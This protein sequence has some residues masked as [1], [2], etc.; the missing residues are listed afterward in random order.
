M[1]ATALKIVWMASAQLRPHPVGK[2]PLV[3]GIETSCDDTSAALY[4]QSRGLIAHKSTCL[5]STHRP[6]NGVVPELASRDHIGALL[7]LVEQVLA[8]RKPDAVACT[9]GPGL[10][11]CLAVGVALA[12]SLAWS[13]R[14]PLAAVH[15]LEGHLLSPFLDPPPD[16]DFPYLALLV[17]GGHTALYDVA[18]PGNYLLLGETLDDA[19]GE[20]F[21][22]TATLLGLPYPGAAG[23]EKLARRGN[24]QA[25][26]LPVPMLRQRGLNF[27]FSGLKTAARRRLEQGGKKAD[28]AAAFQS[29]AIATLAGKTELAL[30]RTRRKRLAVVGG[31]ACNLALREALG[32]IADQRNALIACPAAEFCTDNAAMIAL[33]GTR[34]LQ[35]GYDLKIR[36][37]WPLTSTDKDAPRCSPA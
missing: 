14:V 28:I 10:A 3:L 29:A 6:Y 15:H 19:A 20:A 32:K 30:R 22:K 27:S 17:S 1:L 13:W 35:S 23:L 33:A 5:S 24:E 16:F 36:P 12:Q 26:S 21:D 25:A 9:T 11:G 4:R 2:D 31:V 18:G 34:H 8:G 7:P 37:R